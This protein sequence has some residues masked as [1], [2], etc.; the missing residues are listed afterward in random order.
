MSGYLG[1][2]DALLEPT[3]TSSNTAP[4]QSP[5]RRD[6]AGAVADR[7]VA[8]IE[9]GQALRP[10]DDGGE[11][12]GAT[13]VSTSLLASPIRGVSDKAWTRF[14]SCMRTAEPR[15]ISAS[16]AL[17]AWEMKPRRLS[18]LGRMKELSSVRSPSGRMAWTGEW[19]P[20]LTTDAFLSDQK[21]QYRTFSESMTRY[22]AGLRDGSIKRPKDGVKRGTTLS[23][24]LAILHR[25]GPQALAQWNID[26]RR[27][28][29]TVALFEKC[30]GIF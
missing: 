1:G 21:E 3:S 18:D 25:A 2:L 20:P 26:E 19:V 15:A 29:D 8:E 12:E 16:N 30:N 13:S 24:V 14:V 10:F 11:G 7:A 27:F 4:R 6:D 23:G 22:V 9:K 28:P 5:V 17:G